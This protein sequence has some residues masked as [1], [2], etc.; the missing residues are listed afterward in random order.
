MKLKITD[1]MRTIGILLT[2]LA[3]LLFTACSNSESALNTE[4]RELETEQAELE[5]EQEELLEEQEE[6]R[7]EYAEM[8]KEY[9]RE[10]AE[11]QKEQKAFRKSVKKENPTK[12]V[13]RDTTMHQLT[14]AEI[15]ELT[16][17]VKSTGLWPTDK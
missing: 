6:L 12:S 1:D 3:M 4:Q 10:K 14:D 7:R 2:Y 9:L 5:K 17:K 11:F 13:K 8:K 15:S 16:D